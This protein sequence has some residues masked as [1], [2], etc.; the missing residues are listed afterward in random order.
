MERVDKP[1]VFISYAWSSEEYRQKVLSFA[2]QLINDG[3]DVLFDRYLA[4]GIDLTAFMESSVND[5][6]VTNVLILMDKVYTEKAN[7]RQG[8]VGTETQIISPELYG[9]VEQTKFI[10]VLFER[11]E[12]GE[13]R[14]PTFLKSRK[15]IDLTDPETYDEEYM[16]LVKQIYGVHAVAKPPLGTKPAWVDSE[17]LVPVKKITAYKSLANCFSE[18]ERSVKINEYL[19]GIKNSIIEAFTVTESYK[20]GKALELYENAVPLRNEFLLLLKQVVC[21]EHGEEQ[22]GDFFEDVHSLIHKTFL[23]NWNGKTAGLFVSEL[24]IYTIAVYYK[25]HFYKELSSFFTRPYFID[26][27]GINNFSDLYVYS[28]NFEHDMIARDGKKY[29]SGAAEFWTKNINVD[30]CSI[31]EFIFADILAYNCSVYGNIPSGRLWWYPVTYIYAGY[32][33]SAFQGFAQ[34]LQST[35]ALTNAAEMFGYDMSDYPVEQFRTKFKS[36]ETQIKNGE[37][38]SYGYSGAFL[39]PPLLGYYIKLDQ[40]GIMK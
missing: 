37:F 27:N 40:L 24:F 26:E 12:N 9:K 10:P 22:L 7:K 15:F 18:K 32:S 5:E 11:D 20:E 29:L 2:D 19:S 21:V 34:K 39:K 3:V 4:P 38:R 6:S 31:D 16:K 1:K 33:Q 13:I 28:E 25:F 23:E 17:P 30:I 35:K 14:T 36:V 8:G